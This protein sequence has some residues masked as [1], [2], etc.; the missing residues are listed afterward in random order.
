MQLGPRHKTDP[1]LSLPLR[2]AGLGH[3]SIRQKNREASVHGT[4]DQPAAKRRAWVFSTLY[5]LESSIR[6]LVA[7]VIP[8]TAYELLQDEQKVSVLYF[9]VSLVSLFGTLMVPMLIGMIARRRVYS[10]G[11]IFFAL[12]S[13]LMATAT[14]GGL[15]VGMSLR[16]VANSCVSVVLALY[17]MDSIPKT[18]LVRAESLR[19]SLSTSA[20]VIGP[21][22]GGWIYATF[23]LVAIHAVTVGVAALLLSLFWYFRLGEGAVIA[24][25]K[26]P[27]ANPFKNL[28][29]FFSQPRLRLA[30]LIAFARSAFWTT[31]FVYGPIL[32]V[33]AGMGKMSGGL[34]LSAGNV[35]L[36]TT[37]LWAR[38]AKKSGLRL[39][40]TLCFVALTVVLVAAGYTGDTWPMATAVILLVAT[41]FGSALD[42]M[43]STPF[44]RA[45]KGRER[46][47]MTS[48][49]R[50][51]LDFS[52]LVP[53]AIFSIV[54]IW[55]G[56]GSIFIVLAVLTGVTSILT[57]RYL[58]KSM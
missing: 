3:A 47:A 38:A 12:A 54:L 42:G 41:I 16:V 24:A 37:V 32:L 40:I 21:A 30:W 10:L 57:W 14:I 25:A 17:I 23:G 39:L 33:A 55:F 48:V 8:I 9:T 29:R 31:Y 50:T 45:V 27:P 5:T 46:P 58:P 6:G 34:F 43:G 19:M 56:F 20:W 7:S 13:V 28:H 51:F 18:E 35:M 53:Q 49:Y 2:A 4:V 15:G 52:D 26:S 1:S 11:V 22:L 44:L 36:L